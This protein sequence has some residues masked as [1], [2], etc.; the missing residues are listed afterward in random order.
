M[1]HHYG[2]QT[3]PQPPIPPPR[4]RQPPGMPDPHSLGC[5]RVEPGG[6]GAQHGGD[7]EALLQP[8]ED[9][10]APRGQCC[11]ERANIASDKRRGLPRPRSARAGRPSAAGGGGEAAAG[12]V[13]VGPQ[14]GPLTSPKAPG[15]GRRHFTKPPWCT[16]GTVP[17]GTLSPRPRKSVPAGPG[18]S[19][20]QHLPLSL[21]PA[22][23]RPA[24]PR[25]RGFRRLPAARG[26]VTH[27]RGL[28]KSLQLASSRA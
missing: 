11:G 10:P 14:R 17:R 12:A 6:R 4:P 1:D 13:P 9:P 23:P 22:S 15:A 18:A 8:W 7:G 27:G 26:V 24:V 5:R 28:V 21:P 19:E 3:P 16:T 2:H 20:V 25:V